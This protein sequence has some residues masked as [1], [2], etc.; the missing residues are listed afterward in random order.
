MKWLDASRARLRLLFARR[1]AESR[2]TQEFQLH[3]ELE[4]EQLMRAKGLAPDEARRQ[5]VVA[6]GGMETHKE[7]LRDGR[8]LAWL[9]G[10]ALDLKLAARLLARYP[11]LTV[12][13]GAAMAFGIAAGVGAFEIRKQIGRASCRKECRSRGSPDH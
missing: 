9:G 1:A 5:A 7:S 6:F 11:W 12:V 3:I 8:G 10:F 2:M 13:A 4:T